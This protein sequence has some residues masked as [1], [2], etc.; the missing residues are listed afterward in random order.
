VMVQTHSLSR[1][2]NFC[3]EACPLHGAACNVCISLGALNDALSRT[4]ASYAVIEPSLVAA[5]ARSSH[6]RDNA[7][8]MA[9]LTVSGAPRRSASSTFRLMKLENIKLENIAD[10]LMNSHFFSFN[11]KPKI[12]PLRRISSTSPSVMLSTYA[13]FSWLTKECS[14]GWMVQQNNKGPNRS[15]CCGP[16]LE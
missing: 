16:S 12:L 13:S 15:P 2:L 7:V 3:K 4:S 11:C 5:L 9:V 6:Q 10:L 1:S 14:N 8:F